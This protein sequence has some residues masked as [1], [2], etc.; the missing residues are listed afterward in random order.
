LLEIA[1]G[2]LEF[3]FSRSSGPGGQNVNRRATKAELV[4]D[5]GRSPSLS[6][7]QRSRIQSRL[8]ARIDADGR[9]HVV[10]QAGRTQAENRRR[11]LERFAVL[12]QRA[13]APPAPPR[14]RTTPSKAAVD[15]RLREK[16]RRA[17]TKRERARPGAD[18]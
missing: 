7:A 2:E 11:A 14:K 15:R 8:A 6:A 17:A 3:R 1:D 4:F 5:V 9:L 18:D 13:V 16:R 12:V 10:S